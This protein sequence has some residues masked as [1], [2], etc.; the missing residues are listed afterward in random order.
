MVTKNGM[1][2]FLIIKPSSLGDIVHTLPLA[3][4]LK[5]SIP[6]SF[7]GWIVQD[8]FKDLLDRDPAIDQVYPI[9]ISSTSDPQ[10]GKL[11]Y[12]KAFQ[13]TFLTLKQLRRQLAWSYDHVLDLQAS[14]RSGL[15]G[16][17]APGGQRS[18]FKDARELNTLFQHKLVA[19]PDHIEHALEK[20]L[21]FAD[22]FDCPLIDDDFH[23]CSNSQ[24]SEKVTSFLER[25]LVDPQKQVIYGHCSARWQTK[26][27]PNEHW[28]ALADMV[29]ETGRIMV[30]GGNS[31]DIEYI[32][33]ITRLMKS[34]PMVAAG[35]LSLPQSLA[36]MKRSS[37]YVGLD[38]GPM[39]MAAMASVPVVALFG[40]TH[41]SRVGPYKVPHRIVRKEELD[42]IECRKRSCNHLSCM[43]G[44]SVEMV[45]DAVH[46]LLDNKSIVVKRI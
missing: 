42:C 31:N 25:G 10:S 28:A 21:L 5:R 7:L 13:E 46:T 4:A 41:P 36:L 39:H 23:I 8:A 14:F 44:I 2:R 27:W 17:T 24:D 16:L 18:G 29:A 26:F 45:F 33:T 32:S 3:H 40:P 37:L 20:N 15:L 22:H 43:K 1:K 6:G 38:S 11:A 9:N 35:Q 19:T 30:F 34:K 12:F